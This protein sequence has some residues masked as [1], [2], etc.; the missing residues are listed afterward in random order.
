MFGETSEKVL[1]LVGDVLLTGMCIYSCGLPAHLTRS[2]LQLAYLKGQVI[3]NSQHIQKFKVAVWQSRH[4][5]SQSCPFIFSSSPTQTTLG[6][7]QRESLLEVE[8]FV[9]RRMPKKKNDLTVDQ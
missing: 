2:Q 8:I 1:K 6:F 3:G 9:L 5:Q 4:Q 7:L